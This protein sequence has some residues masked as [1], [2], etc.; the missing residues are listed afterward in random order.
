MIYRPPDS[1][2]KVWAAAARAGESSREPHLSSYVTGPGMPKMLW[3]E[4]TDDIGLLRANNDC[5]HKGYSLL[6]RLIFVFQ[7]LY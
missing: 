5:D 3:A 7:T 4:M 6:R 1:I 2:R